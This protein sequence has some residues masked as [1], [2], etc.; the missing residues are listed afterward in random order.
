M[1]NMTK[2]HG[3]VNLAQTNFDLF[4]DISILIGITGLLFMF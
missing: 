2:K 4:F 3:K 1:T